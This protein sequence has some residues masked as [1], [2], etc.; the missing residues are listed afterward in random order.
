M[1][2]FSLGPGLRD[3]FAI[4]VLAFV[5]AR[6]C[7]MPCRASAFCSAQLSLLHGDRW[8]VHFLLSA[9]ERWQLQFSHCQYEAAKDAN[10][11]N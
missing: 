10:R 3:G 11:E 8:L 4:I 1:L 2:P 6:P 9:N 5:L 7:P